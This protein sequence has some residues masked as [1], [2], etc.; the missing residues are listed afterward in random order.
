[1]SLYLKYRP[2]TIDELDLTQVRKTLGEIVASGAL[3]HAYLFTGPRGAGKTS[4]ARIL[5]RVVNC[6]KNRKHLSEPCNECSACQSILSGSAVDVIEIDAASNRG[7]DDVRDLREK[8]RLAPAIL[9]KKVYIIDEVHMMTADAFNALLKTLEEPPSHSLFILATTEAHKVPE[10]IASRCV[11]VLFNKASSEEMERSLARV[12]KG[13]KA[14]VDA[15]ALALLARAVDGSFRDGVKILEQAL[16]SSSSVTSADVEELLSGARGWSSV[17]LAAALEQHDMSRSLELARV[18][19]DAG[20]DLT[21]LLVELMRSLKELVVAGNTTLIPLIYQLDEVARKLSTS[22]VPEILLEIAIIAWC[23]GS[24]DD[25]PG[26]GGEEKKPQSKPTN[27]VASRSVPPT[28][29]EAVQSVSRLVDSSSLWR[30]MLGKLNGDSQSMGALLSAARPGII[31]GNELTIEVRYDFH[32][33]QIMQHKFR[34]RIEELVSLVAGTPIH[35]VC[36]VNPAMDVLKTEGKVATIADSDATAFDEA[37]A[38]FT[39]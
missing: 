8:I 37:A 16:I 39:Q 18:A 26:S 23:V 10:T 1:M 34:R 35:I 32:R 12:I 14:K 13:E 20:V 31:Q 2:R 4:A 9:P 22:P 11:R 25:Q 5:A 29:A 7:I 38:I 3:S 36:L 28:K 33:E 19:T 24:S 17:E 6:E 15:E 21:Y 27:K 30:E